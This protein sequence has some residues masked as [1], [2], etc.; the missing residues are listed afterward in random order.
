LVFWFLHTATQL[1]L[2]NYPEAFIQI[3]LQTRNST[4]SDSSR[5]WKIQ[6]FRHCLQ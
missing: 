4:A 2:V 1:H 3:D 5:R 6:S